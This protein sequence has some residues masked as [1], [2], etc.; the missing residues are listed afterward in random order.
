MSFNSNIARMEYIVSNISTLEYTFN[1]QI[2]AG[3]DLIVY[4]VPYGDLADDTTQK[5][6]IISDYTVTINGDTGG[7]IT[8]TNNPTLNDTIVIERSLDI[9][10]NY[11]Y[12]S[13]GGIYADDLNNDQNYQTLLISDESL[14]TDRALKLPVSLTGV[15]ATITAPIPRAVI[16]WSDDGTKLVND[17][18]LGDELDRVQDQV[19]FAYDWATEAHN[20]LVDDGRNIPDYSSY[21]YAVDSKASEDISTTNA[22]QTADDRLN[23]DIR[24]DTVQTNGD[25]V[26]QNLNVITS[27][28]VSDYLANAEINATNAHLSADAAL[29]SETNAKDSEDASKIS[30]TNALASENKANKWADE[31]A[32]VEVEPGQYSSYHWAQKAED[33]ANGTN[34]ALKAQDVNTETTYEDSTTTTQYKIYID[35]GDIVMEE[36]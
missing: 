36:L 9:N 19:D 17:A 23:V 14:A 1:Y 32:D 20:V 28:P 16:R 35:N 4:Q 5:L 21:S 15:D 8:L 2:F 26:E 31:A 34:K 12:V 33:N 3:E 29:L 24:L 11:D 22:L 27:T 13:N 25:T 10:R 30:E 6:N 18:E 7:Y